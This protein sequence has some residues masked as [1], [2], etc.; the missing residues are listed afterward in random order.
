M[1]ADQEELKVKIR[2]NHEEL[3][4]IMKAGWQEIGAKMVAWLEET[5]AY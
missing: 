1:E 4:P 2:T 3:M 5:K